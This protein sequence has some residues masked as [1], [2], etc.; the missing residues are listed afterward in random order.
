VSDAAVLPFDLERD[1]A[2]ADHLLE[3]GDQ[4]LLPVQ[5]RLLADPKDTITLAQSGLGR[6]RAGL[7]LT[8][9]GRHAGNAPQEQH[10]VRDDG[11]EEIEQRSGEQHRDP[12]R[13]GA[14]VECP[15]AIRRLDRS[16]ALVQELDVAAERDGGD[17]EFGAVPA[18]HPGPQRLAE[19]DGIPEHLHAGPAAHEEMTELVDGDQHA[20]GDHEGEQIQQR[21]VHATGGASGGSGQ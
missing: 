21:G 7:H 16:L 9:G 10:P 1:A 3:H 15:A 4:R 17:A 19:A 11:E 12:R 2:V 13:H 18:E 14:M 20:D 8:H 6:V 5:W